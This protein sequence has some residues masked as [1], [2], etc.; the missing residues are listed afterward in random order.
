MGENCS[1]TSRLIVQR[2]VKKELLER[3]VAH[4]REWPMGDP[5]NPENRVGALVSKA[6]FEK[7][8]SYLGKGQTILLG[9][10]AKDGFVEPTIVDVTDREAPIV[11]EEVFGPVLAVVTVGS[12]DEAIA[13]AND[14]EYGLAASIYT[15]NA[16]RAIRGARAIRAGTVTVNSFGEGDITTPFGGFRQSGFGGRDNGIQAHDQY[17]QLKTIWLDLSDDGSESVS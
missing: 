9:G 6:H 5:L 17:T 3:I 2:G 14:T 10:T 4:A 11:R 12:L 16:K 15:A 13:M 1:A 7:V 8:C